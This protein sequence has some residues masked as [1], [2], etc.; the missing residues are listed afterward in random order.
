MQRLIY[1]FIWSV[2]FFEQISASSEV[3]LD[4]TAHV[5]PEVN[6]ERIDS[7][8]ILDIFQR[9]PACY[10]VTSNTKKNIKVT[11]SSRNDW[12]LKNENGG[13]ELKNG[14]EKSLL[15]PYIGEFSGRDRNVTVGKG[16]ESVIIKEDCFYDH[17]YDFSIVFRSTKTMKNFDAGKYYDRIT[18]SVSTEE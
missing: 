9:I 5:D 6:I 11:F 16:N 18:I 13:Q 3:S 7:N 12:T 15:I 2:F 1:F 8:G 10:R 17:E 14:N 4:L